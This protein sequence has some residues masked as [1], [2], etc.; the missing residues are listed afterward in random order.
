MNNL[1]PMV[2]I[3][4]LYGIF[5]EQLR[6]IAEMDGYKFYL[7]EVAAWAVRL[8]CSRPVIVVLCGGKTSSDSTLSEALSVAPFF[9]ALLAKFTC[10]NPIV[11]QLE[12][13][14]FNTPQNISNALKQTADDIHNGLVRIACDQCRSLKTRIVAWLLCRRAKLTGWIVQGFPREDI[15]PRSNWLVQLLAGLG[16]LLPWRLK[17]DLAAT[18]PRK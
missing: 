3:V 5:D 13:Q 17:A 15:H 18:G 7:E 8:S 6:T 2:L 1:D 14:S 9:E 10:H 11:I 16:Y 4:C 12:E